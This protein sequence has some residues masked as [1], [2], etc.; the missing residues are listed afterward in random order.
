MMQERDEKGLQRRV[1]EGDSQ[2]FFCLYERHGRDVLGIL[3]RLTRGDRAE[4][5][6]LTQE[7]FL[8]AFQGRKAFSGRVPLRAW[9][10]GIAVR[11][12]RDGQ[13]RPRPKTVAIEQDP[14][15]TA[16]LENQ[17]AARALL[18]A[19]LG[20]LPDDQQSAVLLVLAQG[21]TYREAAEALGVPEGTI[22]WRV[23]EASKRLRA[24]LSEDETH[25]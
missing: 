11:R 1:R 10:V 4:A 24:T 14:A 2:G 9:L 21:L 19:A 15:S 22:K 23:S 25:V 6:D 18:G 12:W 3:L 7:T 8:A 5:E 20:R 13:R 17:V 16:Q